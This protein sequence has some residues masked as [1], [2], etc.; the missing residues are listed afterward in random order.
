MGCAGIMKAVILSVLCLAWCS[1]AIAHSGWVDSDC[2]HYN[3]KTGAYHYHRERCDN[4]PPNASTG[5]AKSL[6]KKKKVRKSGDD[7]VVSS[8]DHNKE[9]TDQKTTEGDDE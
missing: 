9:V 1:G 4:V 5:K 2:G 6:K 8:E 7:P 3:R